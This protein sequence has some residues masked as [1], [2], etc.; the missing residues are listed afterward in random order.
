MARQN[1]TTME[2]SEALSAAL[3]H[4]KS[5]VISELKGASFDQKLVT[6]TI[7]G[8]EL[9]PLYS[10]ADLMGLPDLKSA[11]GSPPFLR[12]VRAN[13]INGCSW[14]IAQEIEAKSPVEFNNAILVGL[15]HGQNS[16][17]LPPA[18]LASET[19]VMFSD[20]RALS[21]ALAGVDLS[22]VSVHQ[23]AGAD[24]WPSAALYLALIQER[25]MAS[26]H[27]RGSILA[28]PLSNWANAGQLANSLGRYYDSL[29]SWV[30]W[31]AARAPLLQTVGVNAG[32][33]GDA[34]GTAVQELAFALATATEYLRE[35]EQRGVPLDMA[36]EKMSFQFSIGSQFFT[37][38]AKFRALRP[39]WARILVSFGVD[40]NLTSC[41]SLHAVTCRWNKTLLDPHVNM[42]RVT[43]EA[44]SAVLGGCDRLHIGPYNEVT[45]IT[46]AVSRRVACN[47]H[48]I[49]A[50]ECGFTQ[51]ADPAGGSWYVEKY[52]D[53]LARKAWAL[54]QDIERQGGFAAALHEGTPQRLVEKVATE[55]TDAVGTRRLRLIGTNLFPNLKEKPLVISGAIE[56]LPTTSITQGFVPAGAD[57][58][59]HLEAAINAIIGGSVL[60]Q[61]TSLAVTELV[62]KKVIPWR[63]SAGYE[64]LREASN[65]YFLDTGKRPQVFIAKMGAAVQHKARADFSAEFFSAG[66]F[67]VLDKHNFETAEAAATAFANSGASIAVLCSTDETYPVLVPV[68]ASSVKVAHQGIN[69]VVLAGLPAEPALVAS[70]IAAGIDEFLH[71]RTNA[72]DLLAKLL[73]QNG[74]LA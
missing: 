23:R 6:R 17:V 42:L 29:A 35:L 55:K 69:T 53:E 41:A 32:I 16:V 57:W 72:Y 46:D 70:Y 62:I 49:L 33:W 27:L 51:P 36:A 18:R 25:S 10:R 73:K 20:L 61:P 4:W 67:E 71:V 63:A 37:E 11:P 52:T 74:A 38:I 48:T 31:A 66:G 1:V 60:D 3:A 24:A 12:G 50:D 22:A 68:F 15:M 54:F 56:Q 19:G 44:L 30:K 64:R 59:A 9:Q 26:E 39:L 65:A 58:P 34:G 45:G 5:I 14:E 7:E 13:G 40:V 21:A 2:S 43:T 8:V 47:V 28:D